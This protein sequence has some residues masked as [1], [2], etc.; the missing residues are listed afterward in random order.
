[1]QAP[2]RLVDYVVAHELAH[3]LHLNHSA[4]F[5]RVVERIYP[6]YPAA[7]TELAAVSRHYMSL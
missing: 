7:R 2:E 3:L 4:R 1:M 6:D 5:W